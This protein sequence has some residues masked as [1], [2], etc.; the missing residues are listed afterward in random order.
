MASH[1][2][3]LR[4]WKRERQEQVEADLKRTR[5]QDP[6]ALVETRGRHR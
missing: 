2:A 5:A 6:S 1:P 3:A 4:P